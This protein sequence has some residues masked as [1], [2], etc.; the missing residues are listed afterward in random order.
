MFLFSLTCRG[1]QCRAPVF[2]RVKYGLLCEQHKLWWFIIT[3]HWPAG[4][5]KSILTYCTHIHSSSFT[6]VTAKE[7]WVLAKTLMLMWMH[8][9]L[10]ILEQDA[11]RCH[12]SCWGCYLQ[13]L[14]KIGISIRRNLNRVGERGPRQKFLLDPRNS[15]PCWG[16]GWWTPEWQLLPRRAPINTSAVVLPHLFSAYFKLTDENLS[17]FSLFLDLWWHLPNPNM[18][19]LTCWCLNKLHRWYSAARKDTREVKKRKY[20]CS[21]RSEKLQI[22]EEKAAVFKSLSLSLRTS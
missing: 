9:W 19:H 17:Q 10:L 6:T 3:A 15:S 5:A 14:F 7:L 11:C 2:N 16:G 4:R 8:P 20:L 13:L 18:Q 21:F 12:L 22:W 1:N